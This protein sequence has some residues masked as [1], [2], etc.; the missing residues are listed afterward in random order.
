MK[1]FDWIDLLAPE[2]CRFDLKART[3][4]EALVE[5]VE[6]M[7]VECTASRQ[8]VILDMLCHREALGSTALV[9]GAAFPHGR[10]LGV[11]RSVT[12]FGRS[13]RGIDFG[14]PDGGRTHLF[15]AMLAP[16]QP[17]DP[18][19]LLGLVSVMEALRDDAMRERLMC[20]SNHA[21]LVGVLRGGL[22]RS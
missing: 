19:Y 10:S 6:L 20:V 7:G 1:R 9:R 13:H 12:L 3:K 8:K 18:E 17:Y 4:Y 5:L 14:A 11:K 15:F 2:L 16:A 22:V 21:E